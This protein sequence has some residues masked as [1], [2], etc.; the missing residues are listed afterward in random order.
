MQPPKPFLSNSGY[1]IKAALFC[2]V[3]T[4]LFIILS[5]FKSAF[6]P[7][8]ERLVHGI[9]G[10]VA[11]FLVTWIFLRADK[12]SFAAIGLR[13]EKSTVPKFFSGVVIGIILMGLL[14][15]GV[16]LFSGFTIET[17]K[18][19]S[20]FHFLLLTLPLIPLAFMEELAFRG[21]PLVVIKEQTGFRSAVLI[22]AL[23]FGL[24]HIAN[25]W[26]IQ[27]AFLGAGVWG[28]IYGMGAVYSKGI[29]LSTGM[30]YAANLTTS[31]F[32]IAD[33]SF[34]IWVL[35]QQNGMSLE[36]YQSS[37]LATILPQ[38]SLLLIGLLIMYWYMKKKI[39][40]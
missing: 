26:T 33:D 22:T 18:N 28:I 7:N 36:N 19:S 10:T 34:N 23:L 12:I 29:S 15:G 20:F 30:H 4:G 24:Y 1:L 3:F 32:G 27:N 5:F 11:A 25:G 16:V 2:I 9:I 17:N 21:Y 37:G 31:A 39:S 13:F 35:K 14:L 38:L 40:K 8:A 6:P